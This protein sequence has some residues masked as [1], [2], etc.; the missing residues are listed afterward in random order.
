MNLTRR[1]QIAF[2]AL[3]CSWEKNTSQYPVRLEEWSIEN[4]AIGQ[5]LVSSLVLLDQFP[6]ILIKGR[7]AVEKKSKED[8]LTRSI[9]LQTVTSAE[10]TP[11]DRKSVV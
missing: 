11:A 5:S 8:A 3:E 4:P 7:L 9:R 10:I 1:L 2:N 6:G